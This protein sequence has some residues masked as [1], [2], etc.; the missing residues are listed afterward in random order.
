MKGL[1][2]VE[3]IFSAQTSFLQN[4]SYISCFPRAIKEKRRSDNSVKKEKLSF[5]TIKLVQ[6][7]EFQF[8]FNIEEEI[9]Y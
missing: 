6:K 9:Q 3:P 4:A 5:K 2:K 8:Y 1:T 7:R